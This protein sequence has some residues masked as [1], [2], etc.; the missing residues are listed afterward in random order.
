M[1]HYR[2]AIIYIKMTVLF[3]LLFMPFLG[4][5]HNCLHAKS[6]YK[7]GKVLESLI[8]LSIKRKV[9][10]FDGKINT[11]PPI[12]SFTDRDFSIFRQKKGMGPICRKWTSKW[13]FPR[14]HNKQKHKQ[15]I[16]EISIQGKN[17]RIQWKDNL[18]YRK[19]KVHN[20]KS[21]MIACHIN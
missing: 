3:F 4:G 16:K 12:S 13:L 19:N 5:K 1:V 9:A 11:F 8:I 17:T 20:A 15:K 7:E 18:M 10:D 2:K 21:F 14:R 6:W